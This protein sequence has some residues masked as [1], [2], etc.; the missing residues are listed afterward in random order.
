MIG[1]CAAQRR[2][3][4]YQDDQYQGEAPA[5]P[6]AQQLQLQDQRPRSSHESTTFIPIIRF[7]KEQGSDGSYKAAYVF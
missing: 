3:A 4:P 5:P 1:A 7:D 2:P 6:P